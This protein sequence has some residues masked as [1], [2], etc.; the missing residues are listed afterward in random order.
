M[1]LTNQIISS[2]MGFTSFVRT[3]GTKMV[4]GKPQ[5]LAKW[6]QREQQI[7]P[8]QG[9]EAFVPW[10]A[11]SHWKTLSWAEMFILEFLALQWF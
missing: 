10:M 4:S 8:C 1:P 11:R 7:V 3:E 6:T 9:V 5:D 2:I